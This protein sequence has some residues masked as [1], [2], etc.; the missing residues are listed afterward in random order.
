[1]LVFT[2]LIGHQNL[3]STM[4][5]SALDLSELQRVNREIAATD[6]EI[7]DLVFKLYDITAK[8]REIIEETAP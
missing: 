8:E 1:V 4:N 5:S 2:L 6:A 3:N 7:D